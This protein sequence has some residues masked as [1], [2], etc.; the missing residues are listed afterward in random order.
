MS[1]YAA[2]MLH[3]LD[4]TSSPS[5]RHPKP[6]FQVRYQDGKRQRSAGI[7]RTP[8]AAE[9]ARRRVEGG[10]APGFEQVPLEPVGARNS[11]VD[12]E[13]QVLLR[14]HPPAMIGA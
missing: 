14:S 11:V 3:G 7:Y 5:P 1:L 13:L 12:A 2:E 8:E 4:R 10:P 9:R 6:R